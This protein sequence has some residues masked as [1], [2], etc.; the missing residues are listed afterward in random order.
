MIH[1][2]VE[3]YVDDLVVKSKEH[4]D[5]INVLRKVFKRHKQGSK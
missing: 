4:E 2:E 1:N 3:I 5:H